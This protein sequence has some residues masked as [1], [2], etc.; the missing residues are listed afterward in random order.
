MQERDNGAEGLF[1][2]DAA[3]VGRVVDEGRGDEVAL[4]GFIVGVAPT[5]DGV[6][7]I[8]FDVVEVGEDFFVLDGVLDGT[9]VVVFVVAGAELEVL[10]I[11]DE[12][13]AEAGVDGGVD[14][15]A[16]D[17]HADLAR[18]DE[19]ELGDLGWISLLSRYCGLR[20]N[21]RLTGGTTLSKS[22]SSQTM[23]A[24]FPPNSRVH[25]LRVLL[26]PSITFFPTAIE[27]VKLILSMSGW[28]VHIGPKLCPPLSAWITPGGKNCIVNSTSLRPQYGVSGEGFTMMVLPV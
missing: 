18:V 27:P 1:L 4:P 16:F 8:V 10:G 20:K 22:T 11:G 19:A 2:H 13:V 12:S 17:G 6:E 15:D 24:S 14:V 9:D 3:G 21:R 25:R 23:A 28:A 7:V 5:H 26:Q